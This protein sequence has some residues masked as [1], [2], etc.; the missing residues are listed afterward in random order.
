MSGLGTGV[1]NGIVPLLS[2][3]SFLIAWRTIVP[4]NAFPFR[5]A[6]PLCWHEDRFPNVLVPF[7]FGSKVRR[8][9]RYICLLPCLLTCKSTAFKAKVLYISENRNEKLV[10]SAFIVPSDETQI[11]KHR[12]Y[13]SYS[14]YASQWSTNCD[15]NQYIIKSSL[16]QML[17]HSCTVHVRLKAKWVSYVI[18]QCTW[19]LTILCC[20]WHVLEHTCCNH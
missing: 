8:F 1:P 4:I 17:K 3:W 18:F 9:F 20:T 10:N 14:L 16:Q 13:T 15:D 7:F 2:F 12:S 6:V 5:V 11:L 19:R